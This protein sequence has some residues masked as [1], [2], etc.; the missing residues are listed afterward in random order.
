MF[1]EINN[2][3]ETSGIQISSYLTPVT[4]WNILGEI[5]FIDKNNDIW[6]LKTVH[7]ITLKHVIQTLMYNLMYKDNQ[8]ISINFIN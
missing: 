8:N 3:I 1:D 2:Y 6:E 4:K 7:E 5:D